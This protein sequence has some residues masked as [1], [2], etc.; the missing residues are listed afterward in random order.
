MKNQMKREINLAKI[1]N[2]I[3]LESRTVQISFM[4]EAPVKRFIDGNM[5]DEVLITTPQTVD[6]SRLNNGA[7]L[8]FN[9]N[10][11]D[12]IGV[13]ERAWIDED[14]VGRA[15]V[16]FSNT[17]YSDDKFKQVIEGV[18]TH[19][20]VGYNIDNYYQEGNTL[21]VDKLT[22][23]EL[24][25][26]SVPAD[27][28][29]GVGRSLNTNEE[30]KE[31]K[32][33]E[34]EHSDD[35][36]L[37]AEETDAEEVEVEAEEEV[38]P[39][40]SGTETETETEED[41]EEEDEVE[42]ERQLQEVRKAIKLAKRNQ[43][44]QEAL[45]KAQAELD[46]INDSARR[47]E[48]ESIAKVFNVDSAEAINNKVSVDEFKRSIDAKKE[49]TITPKENKEMTKQTRTI[50]VLAANALNP[51]VD[52]SGLKT[53]GR[54]FEVTSA[55]LAQGL[56]ASTTTTTAAGAI[57]TNYSD[58][59][60]RPLL[61]ESILGRLNVEVLTGMG[62]R[63]F[64]IPRLTSLD[65]TSSFRFYAEGEEIETTAAHFDQVVLKPRIFAGEIP[66]TKSLQLS[67]PNIGTYIQR[68]LLENVGHSLEKAIIAEVEDTATKMT[69]AAS[70]V[71]DEADIESAIQKLL[72]SN[73]RTKDSVA[74]CSPSMYA[75]LR[76]TA[77]LSNIAGVALAQG[78]RFSDSQ[79]LCEEIPLIVSNF[80]ADGTILMGNF[81]FVTIA[82]FESQYLDVDTT[83]LRN[84]LTTIYRLVAALDVVQ[85]HPE[86]VI[87][88][89]VKA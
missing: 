22:P 81:S 47:R 59:F 75:R 41:S 13:V 53:N 11:D 77:F 64:T 48:I 10:L 31:N 19:I 67:S 73:I 28:N 46:Q 24:S 2:S 74:V 4:S 39:E 30:M 52:I 50:D 76:Q 57:E 55:E 80:V 72:E 23:F 37:R 89:S 71:L 84:R 49:K 79:W 38:K 17:K 65:S 51:A 40:D 56:R 20:S 68:A 8:L 7:A 9:H 29:A 21:Y 88:L 58:D 12:L 15:V 83:T 66:V 18:L 44:A 14:R 26:V 35:I 43:V 87:Q 42:A 82:Q 85:K 86:S 3:D 32:M 33:N 6:L 62:N 70:G 61:A 78:M 45:N 60:I 25:F 36:E 54:G 34:Q 27:V 63:E 69:T 5:Y 1:S 16:R